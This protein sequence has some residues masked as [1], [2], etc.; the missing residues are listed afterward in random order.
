MINMINTKQ[1]YQNYNGGKKPTS[2]V[3][4]DLPFWPCGDT[5]CYG[6]CAWGV[7]IGEG[8][9]LGGN[10]SPRQRNP[11]LFA[12]VTSSCSTLWP[13][14]AI[15]GSRLQVKVI[16]VI[17]QCI[18]SLTLSSFIQLDLISVN[19]FIEVLD[20]GFLSQRCN[21]TENAIWFEQPFSLDCNHTAYFVM[22][23]YK[24]IYEWALTLKGCTV[25]GIH[26]GRWTKGNN[27]YDKP[28]LRGF[29]VN[30]FPLDNKRDLDE[31]HYCYRICLM[32]WLFFGSN[33][34]DESTI[35]LGKY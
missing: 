23:L 28:A 29:P 11:S 32:N 5:G 15:L 17:L 10:M 22:T 9:V 34:V 30:L 20:L 31:Q 4:L 33:I 8:R 24:D 2:D 16:Y 7:G 13:L 18:D 21:L 12:W 14:L 3:E 35:W 27:Q 25:M 19:V 6:L 26:N 1:H